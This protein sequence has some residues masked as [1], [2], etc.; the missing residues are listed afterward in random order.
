VGV[1]VEGVGVLDGVGV[2]VAVAIRVGVSVVV[3]VFVAV[4]VD[5]LVGVDVFVAIGVGVGV[6]V[7]VTGC[8]VDSMKS[9]KLNVSVAGAAVS[10]A[11]TP[12][13]P[14]VMVLSVTMICQRVGSVLP[15][16]HALAR[17]V[18]PCTSKRTV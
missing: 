11:S 17:N 10:E 7:G 18:L 16:S 4:D 8:G 1:G 6:F 14:A 5:V 15:A 13:T 2:S 12:T 3:G 9:S